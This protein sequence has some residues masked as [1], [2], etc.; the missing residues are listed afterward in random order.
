M[1]RQAVK[2]SPSRQLL[3]VAPV[4][5]SSSFLRTSIP[6]SHPYFVNAAANSPS[7][8]VMKRP[9]NKIEEL[10]MAT[11]WIWNECIRYSTIEMIR[12][13]H[14]LRNRRSAEFFGFCDVRFASA[15]PPLI[16]VYLG[17]LFQQVLFS[18]K[19]VGRLVDYLF[20]TLV[21]YLF[22]ASLIIF[23][24]V[25]VN[26]NLWAPQVWLV[27]SHPLIRPVLA[28]VTDI[29]PLYRHL[30]WIWARTSTSLQVPCLILSPIQSIPRCFDW[31]YGY[32]KSLSCV[33]LRQ[34]S[35]YWHTYCLGVA[36]TY[37][38]IM[39]HRASL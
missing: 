36:G 16:A 34:S 37:L 11:R 26:A 13:G 19:L 38:R 12:L 30:A 14:H 29:M 8:Y 18:T 20:D 1:L 22:N 5:S 39:A 3:I 23:R 7:A 24:K 25:L 10:E 28:Y 17:S 2:C 4:T 21:D 31:W 35:F 9:V 27:A 32:Y 33:L 15:A 6:E